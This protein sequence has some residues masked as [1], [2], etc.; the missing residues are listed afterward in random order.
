MNT[1]VKKNKLS[2][3][4]KLGYG[5]GDM[6]SNCF[7]ALVT[8][9]LLAY[10]T[11]TAGLNAGIVGT[12]VLVSKFLD[13]ISDLFFGKLLDN[14]HSK[15]GKARPWVLWSSIPLAV[16][17][18]MMFSV[19][20]GMSSTVQYVY[21]FIVYTAANAICYTANNIA[22]NTLTALVTKDP[23]ERVS[24]G[25]FRYPFSVLTNIL[26]AILTVP[27]VTAFGG[28]ASGWR[29]T[30][31]ILAVV[32]II[33]NVVAVFSVKELPEEELEDNKD[34]LKN[35]GEKKLTFAELFKVIIHNKYYLLMLAIQFLVVSLNAFNSAGAWY[36]CNWQMGDAG[37]I[38]TFS[39]VS[40]AMIGGIAASPA[41]VKRF[42]MYKVNLVSFGMVAVFSVLLAVSGYMK[43]LPLIMV[44]MLLRSVAMGP[45]TG[46]INAL[47]A[48]V[49]MFTKNTEGLSIEGSIYS[50]TSVGQ[51]VGGGLGTAISGWL[52]AFGGYDGLAEVQTPLAL[53]MIN[54]SYLVLP[55]VCAIVLTVCLW[56]LDVEKKNKEW[57]QA[58]STNK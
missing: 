29:M 55:A 32:E 13:G 1:D 58:H 23:A 38:G 57:A 20:A 45:L 41:L 10:L 6:G 47:V 27:M 14:T 52:L 30:A 24:M 3:F 2:V 17:L 40:L 36:F 39:I 35:D 34:S 42:G 49:A 31:L 5:L 54:V 11:D 8:T 21:I 43:S 9:F 18:F 16:C 53:Q 37:L 48:E 51:K 22:Y 46:S 15:M 44:T 56:K 28:G 25:A 26:I 7:Y 19:P 50:C 33:V 4:Q 12:L